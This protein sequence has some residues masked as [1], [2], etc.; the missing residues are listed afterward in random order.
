M[1]ATEI[2]G[3]SPKKARLSLASSSSSFA[4]LGEEKKEA[5]MS[6]ED[7]AKLLTQMA[8]HGRVGAPST[9]GAA[10]EEDIK[11]LAH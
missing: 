5:P 4:N 1:Q 2:E 9:G 6:N 8:M 10:E 3:P 7:A 11:G